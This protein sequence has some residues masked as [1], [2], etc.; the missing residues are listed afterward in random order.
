MPRGR[1]GFEKT[2]EAAQ[3][4]LEELFGKTPNRQLSE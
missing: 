4:Y 1:T 2:S 3:G